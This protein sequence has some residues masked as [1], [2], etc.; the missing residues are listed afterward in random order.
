MS[1]NIKKEKSC[2]AVVYKI[3]NDQRYYLVEK[4]NLGHTSIPKGHVEPTDKNDEDTARRE[5][6]E[7]TSLNVTIDTG[8]KHHINYSPFPGI[9]KDVYFF[10]AECKED[11]IA[12]DDHD[13]EVKSCIWLPI[14][15]AIDAVTFETDK[16]TLRKADEYLKSR[17][18]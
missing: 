10:V 1:E 18:N 4:M 13:D 7:E 11:T 3:I 2:G 16:E 17:N 8:F 12:H 14:K 6:K 9:H 5:I 15:E